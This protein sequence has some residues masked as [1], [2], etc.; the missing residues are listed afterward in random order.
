MIAYDP[1]QAGKGA[2][3]MLVAEGGQIW[4]LTPWRAGGDASDGAVLSPMPGRIIAVAVAA[5]EAVVKG[6]KLLTLEAMEMEHSLVAPFDG[7]IAQ[8]NASEG[9][10]QP[11]A[12]AHRC[13]GGKGE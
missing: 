2:D 6:Q 12:A 11:A 13:G 3:D 4:R 9:G 5:G 10:Q 1:R 8:L 7:T